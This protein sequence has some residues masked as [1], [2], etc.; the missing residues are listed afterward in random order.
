MA[1]K[2]G[3]SDQGINITQLSIEQLSML[4]RQLEEEIETLTN[5]FTQLKG[6]Q[7]RFVESKLSLNSISAKTAGQPILVP[8][9]GSL[10]TPGVL[11]SNEK[12]LIDIGTGYYVEKPVKEAQDFMERKISFLKDNL[13]KLQEPILQKRKNL[14]AVVG[15]LQMKMQIAQQ[16]AAAREKQGAAPAGSPA[17]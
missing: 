17:S 1:D 13:E 8:L 4:K 12:V 3:G 14:E 5:S 9:T 10:Y 15:V 16:V 2:A 6:A 11:G 7:N